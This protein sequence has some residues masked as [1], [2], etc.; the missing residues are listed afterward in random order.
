[1]C[2]HLNKDKTLNGQI[3]F[4][5]V[6]FTPSCKQINDHTPTQNMQSY[7]HRFPG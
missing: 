5:D 4:K 3:L 1:M 7:G 2:T 6:N